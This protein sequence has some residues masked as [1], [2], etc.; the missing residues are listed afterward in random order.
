MSARIAKPGTQAF[1]FFAVVSTRADPVVDDS[2]D[3]LFKEEGYMK[4]AIVAD[5]RTTS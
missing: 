1:K 3:L 5:N 2:N 4:F